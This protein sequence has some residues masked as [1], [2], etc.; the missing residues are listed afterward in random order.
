[1]TGKY[2]SWQAW[3]AGTEYI[4]KHFAHCSL[5]RVVRAPPLLS[6]SEYP[7]QFSGAGPIII[8][9]VGRYVVLLDQFLVDCFVVQPIK[10]HMTFVI[11]PLIWQF[12]NQSFGGNNMLLRMPSF[13]CGTNFWR[14]SIADID[15]QKF[16]NQCARKKIPVG[17]SRVLDPL[18]CGKCARN[19]MA[20]SYVP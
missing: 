2:N 14:E 9:S 8:T 13:K 1:L 7:S 4:S 15:H 12:R 3:Q 20:P 16:S 18:G 17:P 11:C 19:S 6:A 5:R 10:T